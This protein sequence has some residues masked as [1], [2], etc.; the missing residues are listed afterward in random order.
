[1]NLLR[2]LDRADRQRALAPVLDINRR[3]D[4]I[5]SLAQELRRLDECDSPTEFLLDIFD[6]IR[7]CVE[8]SFAAEEHLLQSLTYWGFRQHRDDHRR[9]LGRLAAMRDALVTSIRPVR[10]PVG[11]A[12]EAFIIHHYSF[13]AVFMADLSLAQSADAHA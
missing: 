11:H 4:E 13:D 2:N 12:L 3:F 5:R 9:V 1:M 7:A 8:A 10:P 6:E